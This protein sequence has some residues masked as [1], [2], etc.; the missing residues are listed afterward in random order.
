MPIINVT[1]T[2]KADPA[3]SKR[4]ATLVSELTATHLRKDPTITA[5][6]VNY[7]DPLH[8]FAGGRSLAEQGTNSFWL[9]IK[10]VDGTNTKQEMASY[11]QAVFAGFQQLLGNMHPESY[12]LVHEV[13]AAAYG[14]EG[15]TQ[16][17]RYISNQLKAAV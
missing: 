13:S 7:A 12:I 15:K 1:V 9:D 17:F 16:E 11:L 5:I 8:W 10:V 2:G 6:V 3:L 14:F 4:I